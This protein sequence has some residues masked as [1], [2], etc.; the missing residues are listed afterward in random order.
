MFLVAFGLYL[1]PFLE[2]G[3]ALELASRRCVSS[4]VNDAFESISATS[5]RWD[6]YNTICTNHRHLY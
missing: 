5:R 3:W 4:G 1:D 2:S 6:V